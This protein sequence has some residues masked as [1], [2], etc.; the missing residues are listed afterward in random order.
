MEN[1]FDMTDMGKLSYYLGI[2]VQQR[3]GYVHLKQVG[4]AKNLLEKAGYSDNDL[5]G[6]VKDRKSRGMTSD[7]SWVGH[8]RYNDLK[9]LTE[10]YKNGVDDFI[11]FACD[12][13]DPRDGGLI[14]CPCNDCVNKY[15][16]DPSAVKVDLYL[17]G[18]MEWYTRW[19]LHGE[20]DM[21][22]GDTNTSSH[23]IHYNDEDMYDAR[24]M[25]RDFADANRHFENFVEEP[26][27]K[28]K[29]FYEMVENASEPIYPNNPNFTTLSF[30]NKLL[31][32]KH[33]HNCTNSGFDELIHL[34]GSVLPVDHKLPRNYYDVRKMIRGLHMEYEK[35]DACE[36]D[37]ML[38]YKENRNK[39]HCDI[40]T[41][42]R[43]KE[44]KDPKKNKIPR[45]ILRYFPL[46][47]RLQHLFMNK[48]TAEDMR[49]HHNRVKV[50]GQLCHPAD[51]DEWKQF[52]RRFPNF[53]KEIRNV[54][55]GLSSDGFD[56]FRDS[57]AREYTVWPVVV[58]VYNL[59]P[60][61][62]TKAPYMFMPLLIPGPN[63]P[64]KDL[65]VYLR[66]L[67]DELKIL[68]RTGAETYDRFSCTN[69]MMKAALMW[70][71]SDFP[72]LGMLS[73]WSTKGKLACHICMGQVK[74]NQLKHGG[75]P[76]FYGT[77][78]YFLEP[79]DPLRRFTK[80]GRTEAH[81]VT[82]RY[83]GSLVRSLCEDTQFP[84]SGKTSWRK[85]RDY[86]MTHNW[87]HF[88]PFFE[89]PYWET[90]TLRHNIDVMHTEKNVFENIFFTM[91]GDTKKMKDNRKAREDCKELGVHRELWIQDD[92]TM[93]NAPYVLSRDQLLKLFRWI[94][95]LQLPDGY[96]S[97]ISR[98]VNFETK[99]IH[100]M[101]SHDCHIF[102]QK[103]LPMICRD[104]LPRHVADVLI[105]LSN[106]FQDLCS[107]T[108]KYGDLE[109]ME[110][111]IARIM[112]KLDVMYTP[113]FFDPMEHLPLHLAT[114]CKLGGPCNFR[115]MYFVERYL[116]ILKLKVRNKARV[117]GS[118]AERYIEEEGVHFCSLY[119]DSKI[120]TMHNRLRRNEAPRQ[121]HDPNLLEV[122]TYPT[123][124]GLRNRD[125]ILSDDEHRLVTYYVLINSPEVGKYLRLVQKQY[126]HYNDAEKDQFQKDNFL[127][128]FERRVQD[129][130]ELKDKFI[131]LIRGPIY[132]VES[133]KTCKCNG[134]KFAYANSNELTSSNSGVVVIGTS[135]KESHGNNYGRL[136]EVLKLRY[137]NGHES[138]VFKCHWFDHTRH[139]KIDRNRMITVDVKSKLNAEDVFVLA[140]QAH[141]VYYA[142]NIANPKSSWY[143]ILTT[144]SRQVDESV[145]SRE[146]NIFNDDAFQNEESNASSSHVERV[147]VDDPINFFI[148]LTMFENNHFVDDYEEEQNAR[149]K[150]NQNEDMNIDDGS[151]N[152]DLT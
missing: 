145:T 87:T 107:S 55:L 17:N 78:R 10:E 142:P 134:Y 23:N 15:F 127:D 106:F 57:H 128:W 86:G 135:Y 111:D 138:V 67:I 83:P 100:G 136:Q 150:E 95:T 139:V 143:T 47:Q 51:G 89:L 35:I 27:T 113:S 137:R 124:P 103:L 118:I 140:S 110:K 25:L 40:C 96:A 11:K 132:K 114:E 34:F 4:Y 152:D 38:F 125:R 98:C 126:P 97:N 1:K 49:W 58:V 24:D 79:D 3:E 20:R 99:S 151:D 129:D 29:E 74:A 141:Q 131:D 61:M 146:E 26:N 65:H 119:F 18:I 21:P 32:W 94:Y 80:F 68:W 14:R 82:Y 77:A 112:S 12:H 6:N 116:H 81:S 53:S 45:K 121:S 115:W 56:P 101:K 92:G 90:L 69:F 91:I 2:E 108:L 39:T 88:S 13:L 84:P 147:V 71:I 104:L 144:K 44:Q 75:K 33:K 54:R 30:V 149:N 22:R 36:N 43:Y 123:L 76:S 73:G 85:P 70:T 130:G 72:A 16:K 7:R 28:A 60:S 42:S 37:C 31:H 64:T 8:N 120:A 46:T 48:K 148:D 5:A 59:P 133:Y 50:D 105:E 93:P 19:D 52:D 41:T 117:E 62:C 122:Y 109:K 9:Y 102:M 66:P 63:D